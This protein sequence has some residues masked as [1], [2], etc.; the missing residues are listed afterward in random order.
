MDEQLNIGY[1]TMGNRSCLVVGFPEEAEIVRYQAEMIVSNEISHL[2]SVSKRMKDGQLYLY[3]DISSKITLSQILSRG[4]LKKSQML[5]LIAGIVWAVKDSKEYQLK[6]SGICFQKEY[7]YVD[8]YTC[9]PG[10][11]YLPINKE[12]P[13]NIR[14]FLLELLMQGKIEITSDNFVQVLVDIL[15]MQ[16]FSVDHLE[17]F[18]CDYQGSNRKTASV[19]QKRRMPKQEAKQPVIP[20]VSRVELISEDISNAMPKM[21][22]NIV[23]DPASARVSDIVPNKMPGAVPNMCQQSAVQRQ[24]GSIKPDVQAGTVKEPKRLRIS[25]EEPAEEEEY[26]DKEKAKKKFVLPQAVIMFLL[27][28]MISYGAFTDETGKL[29]MKNVLAAVI[30]VVVVEIILYREAYVNS[31]KKSGKKKT[32]KNKKS[33]KAKGR[34]KKEID[35]PN[36][37]ERQPEITQRT[38]IQKSAMQKSAAPEPA[39]QK[40]IIQTPIVQPPQK[41]VTLMSPSASYRTVPTANIR[42]E[43]TTSENMTA[44]NRAVE[45]SEVRNTSSQNM[46]QRNAASG[47]DFQDTEIWNP[48]DASVGPYLE[49]YQNGIMTRI[50]LDRNSF[51]VGRLAGQVDYVVTN[52]KVGKVHAEFISENGM[53]YVKDLNSKNGTYINSAGQR[54]SSNI[55]YPLK[56]NDKIML[57]NSEFI[58]RCPE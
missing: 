40:P 33:K 3:Y 19:S 5:E 57:A 21:S 51:L 58:L 37:P 4:K 28:A 30:L 55:P 38:V 18:V 12:A 22:Q 36:I 15:N 23:P 44:E 6:E 32:D 46:T 41:E 53:F 49:Y 11:V 16:D 35:I 13:S 25:K 54:I 45:S 2:L 10:F 27:S 31:R 29:A 56:P 52:P 39:V 9:E 43:S 50:L 34:D 1:E 42:M 8:P 7:I 17:R 24:K 20:S 26:F 48:S 47:R 14:N